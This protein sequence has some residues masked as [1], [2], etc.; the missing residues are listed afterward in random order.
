M[1]KRQHSH[2]DEI[3]HSNSEE[4]LFF[5]TNHEENS[6][7]GHIGQCTSHDLNFTGML[8]HLLGDVISSLCVIISSIIVVEY[9]WVYFDTICSIII[10]IAIILSTVPLNYMIFKKMVNAFS[11]SIK[12]KRYVLKTIADVIIFIFFN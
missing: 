12:E 9:D 8:I 2:D 7:I 10:C 5:E 6:H 1:Y 11:I 3:G 4:M